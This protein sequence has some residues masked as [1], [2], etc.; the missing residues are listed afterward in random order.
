MIS[1]EEAKERQAHLQS[2]AQKILDHYKIEQ[3]LKPLGEVHKVGSFQYGLMVRPDIDFQIFT[4]NVFRY[5]TSL[6][7]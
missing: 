2:T 6:G 3:M 4:S 1:I 5:K 7:Q